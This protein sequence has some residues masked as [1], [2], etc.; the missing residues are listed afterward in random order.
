VVAEVAFETKGGVVEGIKPVSLCLR[1]WQ[2][3]RKSGFQVG[4]EAI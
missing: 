1:S 3:W 4:F 2:L